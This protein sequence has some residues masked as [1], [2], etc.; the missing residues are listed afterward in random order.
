MHGMDIDGVLEWVG[1]RPWPKVTMAELNGETEFDLGTVAFLLRIL[2]SLRYL[3]LCGGFGDHGTMSYG[4]N[5]LSDADARLAA[6]NAQVLSNMIAGH[7]LQLQRLEIDRTGADTSLDM[8]A[9]APLCVRKGVACAQGTS[10]AEAFE[11][12]SWQGQRHSLWTGL[13]HAVL[14]A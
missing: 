5:M 7:G 14:L 2:P 10:V 1:W 8:E 4:G 13:Q 6:L 12:A 9:I 3:T 11:R